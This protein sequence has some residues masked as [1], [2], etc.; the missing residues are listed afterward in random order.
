M[1]VYPIITY[2]PFPRYFGPPG[3]SKAKF[4]H[5]KLGQRHFLKFPHPAF[6]CLW[7]LAWTTPFRNYS[8]RDSTEKRG[9]LKKKNEKNISHHFNTIFYVTMI[10]K[11]LKFCFFYLNLWGKPW[12]FKLCVVT[13][14][15]LL[16]IIA[17]FVLMFILQAVVFV[18]VFLCFSVSLYNFFWGFLLFLAS[19]ALFGRLVVCI[20]E[21]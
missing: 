5:L 17:C 15:P 14:F 11:F 16:R 2:L 13:R 19:G 4:P 7:F 1:L 18:F 9:S 8:G 21:T 6:S 10:D 20:Y 3:Y 12:P